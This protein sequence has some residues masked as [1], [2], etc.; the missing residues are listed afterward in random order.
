MLLEHCPQIVRGRG[1]VV[2]QQF[3]LYAFPT[4]TTF[5]KEARTGIHEVKT[6]VNPPNIKSTSSTVRRQDLRIHSD[7]G[8][9]EL[10]TTKSSKSKNVHPSTQPLKSNRKQ[11]NNTTRHPRPLSSTPLSSQNHSQHLRLRTQ[12]ALLLLGISSAPRLRRGTAAEALGGSLVGK[13]R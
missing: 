7:I 6:E 8:T 13:P 2:V 5:G 1:N 3:I 4:D 12:R 10:V 9:N 11:N